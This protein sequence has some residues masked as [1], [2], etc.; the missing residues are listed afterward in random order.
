MTV[1]TYP[2][3]LALLDA[4]N[5]SRDF[6]YRKR[7]RYYTNDKPEEPK[8]EEA[9]IQISWRTGG[10]SGGSC[11]GSEADQPV[12]AEPEPEFEDLDKV[13]ELIKPDLTFLQYKALTRALI[14]T[15]NHTESEYYGNY[16]ENTYKFVNLK[17]LY[18]YFLDQGWLTS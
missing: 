3:F 8:P 11:W 15:D 1:S 7:R 18:D 16:Y 9:Q 4:N 2:E 5:I 12:S 14:Q 6:P 17:Q 13:L 10:M